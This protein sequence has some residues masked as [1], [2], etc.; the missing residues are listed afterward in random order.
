MKKLILS[1]IIFFFTINIHAQSYF[2]EIIPNPTSSYSLLNISE[3]VSDKM[4]YSLFVNESNSNFELNEIT[5]DSNLNTLEKVKT[6]W[7]KG[8]ND[9][10]TFLNAGVIQHVYTVFFSRINEKKNLNELVVLQYGDGVAIERT[11]DSIEIKSITNTGIYHVSISP[12]GQAF[13]V[14][15]E[16]FIEKNR[17]ESAHVLVFT[18]TF[19]KISDLSLTFPVPSKPNPVNKI[20]VTDK[21]DVFIIKKDREKT[22][23]KFYLH[24]YNG[25][26]KGWNQ[27]QVNIPGKKISD[28]DACLNSSQEF[29]VAGFYNTFNVSDYEG[30]FYDR[31]DAS[32]KPMARLNKKFE[33]DFMANF[34]GKKAASKDDAVISDYYFEHLFA[35]NNDEI[36]IIAEKEEYESANGIEKYLYGDILYMQFDKEGSIKNAG[37]LKNKQES[38]N[39]KGEWSSFNYAVTNDTLHLFHNEL[40][41]SDSKNKFGESTFYGTYHSKIYRINQSKTILSN[42]MILKEYDNSI[43]PKAEKLAFHP[44]LVY[45]T[46]DNYLLFLSMSKSKDRY[47]L[48]KVKIK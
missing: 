34:I 36:F 13:A 1:I 45:Q 47:A 23:Y 40:S 43:F 16:D 26:L 18:E 25:E 3:S 22:D 8:A 10:I 44:N 42:E 29:I 37:S 46:S 15:K 17:Q 5:L 4:Y 28:I 7:V 32:L 19:E 12:K 39:D 33:A 14:L 48:G 21:G 2:S 6:S 38:Q 31:F 9:K 11:I 30:Y 20:F 41:E 27:K 24:A 35:G